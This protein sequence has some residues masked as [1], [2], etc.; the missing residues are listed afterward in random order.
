MKSAKIIPPPIEEPEEEPQE[1]S[2]VKIK[3]KAAPKPAA[4]PPPPAKTDEGK[5]VGEKPNGR[6][7]QA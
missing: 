3:P 1:E 6:L 7:Q 5:I 4:R 2:N